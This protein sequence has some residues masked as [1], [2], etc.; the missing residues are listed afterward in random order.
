MTIN[1]FLIIFHLLWSELNKFFLK[2][3]LRIFNKNKKKISFLN[4]EKKSKILFFKSGFEIEANFFLQWKFYFLLAS[5]HFLITY[6]IS[7]YKNPFIPST[8]RL[9]HLRRLLFELLKKLLY[10]YPKNFS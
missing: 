3:F 4:F 6:I 2:K 9:L 10:F 5:F 8:P 1:Y 7:L